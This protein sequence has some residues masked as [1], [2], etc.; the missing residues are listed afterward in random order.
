[1]Q[2]YSSDAL[3]LRTHRYGEADCIVVFLT[4]DR[5]KKRGVAKNAAK[6]RRRFG[7]AL[8]PLTRGTATYVER[9]HRELVWLDR[10]APTTSALRARDLKGPGSEDDS[11][12]LD[13]HALSHLAYFA[14]LLDEWAQDNQAN[15]RLFRL[16]A[17][18]GQA[19]HGG[20]APEALA[21]YFE[22]WLLR[23]EGVYPGIDACDLSEAARAFLT[24]ASVRTPEQVGATAVPADALREMEHVHYRL[25]ATHLEKELRSARVIQ[26]LRS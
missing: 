8:E 26:E 5:G 6:S 9:E 11:G 7:G 2:S 3:V 10:I 22:Y 23:L 1:M 13:A 15:E 25:I 20:G 24:D 19:L 17:A 18:V 21:R 12:G 14:E 4:A 16:G